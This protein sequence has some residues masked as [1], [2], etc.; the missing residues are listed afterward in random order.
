M[1]QVDWKILATRA[2]AYHKAGQSLLATGDQGLLQ[3]VLENAHLA[4]ELAMK[5]VIARNGGLYPD[6]VRR[7]H[8]L[9]DLVLC[10]FADG[11][12]SLLNLAMSM[13]AQGLFNVGLSAW[14]MDCGYAKLE[15][16]Q[17]MSESIGDYA[18]LYEWIRDN[19]LK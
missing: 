2:E 19:L 17:D 15:T 13:K 9:E 12:T 4:L 1:V 10:K 16:Y 11:R 18:R 8:D 3:N 6:Y 5:A 14:S 7:G